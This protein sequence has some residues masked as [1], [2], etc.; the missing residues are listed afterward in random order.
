MGLSA[1]LIYA[2]LLGLLFIALSLRVVLLRHRLQVGIGSGGHEELT[3]AMRAHG[4]FAEYVPLALVL[5]ILV[6]AGTAAS[7]LIVHVLGASLVVARLLHG[8]FGLNRHA[9][10]SAGRLW[11]TA[12]T[13]LMMLISAL[14][15]LATAIGRCLL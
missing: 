8:Y 12:L 14:I 11:G 2:A 6:E 10:T 1:S 15:L 5:L 7:T 4:N 9:G 13:W 3:R